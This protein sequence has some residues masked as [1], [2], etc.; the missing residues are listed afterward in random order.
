MFATREST[1]PSR[2]GILWSVLSTL[3][4]GGA[5]AQTPKK[6]DLSPTIPKNEGS[7]L[8]VL[9][10]CLN[11]NLRA[12]FKVV[13]MSV[14]SETLLKGVTQKDFDFAMGVIRNPQ[15]ESAIEAV[16]VIFA[17]KMLRYSDG[18]CPSPPV[19]QKIVNGLNG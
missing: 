16:R 5:D 13:G 14:Q 3:L 19:L 8:Q 4:S 17:T 15:Y 11:E 18:G 1:S 6:T 9:V 7:M 10:L 12:Q 2:R